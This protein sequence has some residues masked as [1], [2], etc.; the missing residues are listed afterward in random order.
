[1]ILRGVYGDQLCIS[2]SYVYNLYKDSKE[3]AYYLCS[4]KINDL[5]ILPTDINN[6]KI[7]PVIA[8]NDRTLRVLDVNK[9]L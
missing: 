8:C 1:V 6:D 9:R 7:V 4:D 5:Q 2:G 3:I